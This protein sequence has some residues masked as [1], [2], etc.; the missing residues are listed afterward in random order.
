M[1]WCVHHVAGFARDGS[2]FQIDLVMKE[3]WGSSEGVVYVA[4][5]QRP[6]PHEDDLYAIKNRTPPKRVV[7]TGVRNTLAEAKALCRRWG[8]K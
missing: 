2:Y 4:T 8:A 5:C 1:N 3:R 7:L 6:I